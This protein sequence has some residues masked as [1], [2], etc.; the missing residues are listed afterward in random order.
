[1]DDQCHMSASGVVTCEPVV[2]YCPTKRPFAHS[3]GYLCCGSV[4]CSG[5]ETDIDACSSP[6]CTSNPTGKPYTLLNHY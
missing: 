1:M 2:T 3:N 4:D 6:P 5:G